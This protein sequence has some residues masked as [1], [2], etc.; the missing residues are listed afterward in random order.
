MHLM[1]DTRLDPL[2]P[3]PRFRHG[4]PDEQGHRERIARNGCC[5][6]SKGVGQ[7]RGLTNCMFGWMMIFA[8]LAILGVVMMAAAPATASIS[9]KLVTILFGALF[10]VSVLTPLVRRVLA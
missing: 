6:L 8:F 9:C 4:G 10:L 1:S 7:L 3:D 5:E 2:R